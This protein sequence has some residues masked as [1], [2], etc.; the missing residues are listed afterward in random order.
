MVTY[1]SLRKVDSGC[2]ALSDYIGISQ[3]HLK[4]DFVEFTG[5]SPSDYLHMRR[6]FHVEN[7]KHP[8]DVGPCQLIEF[9]KSSVLD[10]CTMKSK[11]A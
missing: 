9:Y 4:K 7:P 11:F 5:H 10:F 3:N 1:V 8:L 6:R 2:L